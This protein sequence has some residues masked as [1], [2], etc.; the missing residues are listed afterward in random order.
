VRWAPPEFG[1]RL[2]FWTALIAAVA[3]AAAIAL[4]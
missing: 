1:A 4:H 2:P 3:V